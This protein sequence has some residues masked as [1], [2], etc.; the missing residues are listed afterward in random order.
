M[1]SKVGSELG[2]EKLI[3]FLNGSICKIDIDNKSVKP[4]I[5]GKARVISILS[6]GEKEFLTN[7][8]NGKLTHFVLQ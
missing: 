1:E 2:S 5:L 6:L 7:N 8:L 3:G 4:L